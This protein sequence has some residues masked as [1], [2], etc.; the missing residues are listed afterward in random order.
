LLTTGSLAAAFQPYW[1]D[2]KKCESVGAFWSLLHVAV[3]L[4]DICAA[5]QSDKG[6]TNGTRYA[7]W[8]DQHW[9]DP[10]LTGAERWDM[11]CRVLHQGRAI[12]NQPSRYSRFAFGQPLGSG[13]VDHKR[14]ENGV[15]HLDVS[16]LAQEDRSAVGRWINGIEQNLGGKDA[17]NVERNLASL[18]Q[19]STEAVPRAALPGGGIMIATVNKTS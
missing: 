11:R 10:F 3:C 16:I 12:P 1:D 5:L 9:V 19:V 6:G 2:M 17:L 18:V 8:C 13:F 4:P 14:V 15:L 7:A